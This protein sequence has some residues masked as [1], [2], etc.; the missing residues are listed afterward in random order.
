M[1]QQ[2]PLFVYGTLM[3]DQRAFHLLADAV[4]RSARAALTDADLH[5]VSWYPLAVPGTGMVHGEV[6]RLDHQAYAAVL[7]R[8]DEYEGDE[9]V[10]LVRPVQLPTGEQVDAW[11]YLGD[12]TPAQALPRLEHGDWRAYVRA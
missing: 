5:V 4:T 6:H 11:V 10:R 8:L 9:Y 1:T 12:P 7:A 2:H 3:S